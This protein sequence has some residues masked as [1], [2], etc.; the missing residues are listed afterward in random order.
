LSNRKIILYC[1]ESPPGDSA[2]REIETIFFT[3]RFV[4]KIFKKLFPQFTNTI[5]LPS[6]SQRYARMSLKGKIEV[7]KK[8]L[9]KNNFVANENYK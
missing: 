7:Y 8:L 1:D 6:P 9:L 4:E 2:G 3:S 5:V